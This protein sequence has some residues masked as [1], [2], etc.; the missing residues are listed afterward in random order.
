MV[1]VA[2]I[3]LNFAAVRAALARGSTVVD[4]L[5][6]GALPMASV[7]ALGGLVGCARPSSRV[8][9][10][11]FTVFGVMASLIFIALTLFFAAAVLMP[12]FALLLTPVERIANPRVAMEWV[13]LAYLVGAVGVGVPQLAFAILGGWLSRRFKIT[14]TRR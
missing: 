3:A 13:P 4:L 11:G 12:Y 5:V 2:V 8:F 14:I 1:I 7:L 10:L 6:I 9:L